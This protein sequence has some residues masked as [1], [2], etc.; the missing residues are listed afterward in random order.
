MNVLVNETELKPK[1][2]A[3]PVVLVQPLKCHSKT[4]AVWQGALW[5][6]S[7]GE[8]LCEIQLKNPELNMYH[9]THPGL[10]K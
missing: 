8:G 9:N 2:G 10:L 1:K 3:A 4:Q 5:E 7:L 6:K